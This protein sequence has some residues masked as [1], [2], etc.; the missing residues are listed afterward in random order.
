M[1]F[2][3]LCTRPLKKSYVHIK[4]TTSFIRTGLSSSSAI[5]PPPTTAKARRVLRGLV[6]NYLTS[7]ISLFTYCLR[8]QELNSTHIQIKSSRLRP[9]WSNSIQ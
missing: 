4:N 8:L 2:Q 1:R 3:N 5:R 7:I 9:K 6:Y